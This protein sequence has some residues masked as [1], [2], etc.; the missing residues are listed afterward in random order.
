MYY[1]LLCAKLAAETL[2]EALKVGDLS[3]NRLVE[4]ERRW[5]RTVGRELRTALM[6]RRVIERLS[7]RELDAL[8]ALVR[9]DGFLRLVERKASFDW[10]RNLIL[11]MCRQPRFATTLVQ[12]LL[13][14]WLPA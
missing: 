14:S 9:R 3:A 2:T 12:G 5:R 4:Y 11:E 8:F 7:D 13:R 1:G 10:H 6:F